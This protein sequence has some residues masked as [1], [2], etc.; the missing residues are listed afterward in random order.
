MLEP[1]PPLDRRAILAVHLRRR[2]VDGRVD[3]DQVALRTPGLTGADLAH[4]VNV[5][6]LLAA[7]RGHSS[8]G[9][10]DVEDALERVTRGPGGVR[11]LLCRRGRELAAYHEAG[12]ALVALLLPGG[13]GAL[14]G[15]GRTLD[16][17]PRVVARSAR[18]V[19]P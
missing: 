7:R 11:R 9:P 5:A 19:R 10:E 14:Q 3:L 8:I 12:H 1:P 6:A 15:D 18:S 2:P 13:L 4:L 16:C 17:G